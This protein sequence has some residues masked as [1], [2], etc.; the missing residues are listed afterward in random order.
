MKNYYKDITKTKLHTPSVESISSDLI[1]EVFMGNTGILTPDNSQRYLRTAGVSTCSVVTLYFPD[2]GIVALSH[3]PPKGSL[4]NFVAIVKRELEGRNLE[5]PWYY[6]GEGPANKTLLQDD[7]F[8]RNKDPLILRTNFPGAKP[9]EKV[10][11]FGRNGLNVII[12]RITGVTR[13]YDM[14]LESDIPKQEDFE[15][16][17]NLFRNYGITEPSSLVRRL[18]TAI[19]NREY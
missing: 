19:R 7:N 1:R 13:I 11:G 2:S 17:D 16:P 18:D 8:Y 6:V 3:M 10:Y 15:N 9:S 14:D 4:P 12:D 5:A